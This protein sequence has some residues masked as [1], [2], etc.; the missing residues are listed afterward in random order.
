MATHTVSAAAQAARE[1]EPLSANLCW[2]LARA[3]FT[4]T[5][6]LTAELDRIGLSP[7]THQ[8]LI[9]AADGGRTQSDL[10]RAVGLDKT[11]MVVTVDELEAAGLAE[12]RPSPTDR[13]ARVIEVTPAG[14]RKLREADAIIHL[15]HEDVLETL[16]ASDRETFLDA[17]TALV[18]GRLAEPVPTPQPVRRRAPRP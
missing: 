4:L 2:L 16:P 17:L 12:R 6:E 1:A 10:V 18:G 9:A 15:V 14:R 3:S 5:T 13:R 8:V 11:T 7:R